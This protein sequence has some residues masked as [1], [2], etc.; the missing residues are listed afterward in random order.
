MRANERM[1]LE[2]DG[3]EA[4]LRQARADPDVLGVVLTGSHAQG[5]A[6]PGSDYDVKVILRDDAGAGTQTRYPVDAFPNVDLRVMPLREFVAYAGWD[7]PFAWDRY[8]FAHARILEDP[9][10]IISALVAEK[11]RI[12]AEHQS[13]FMRAALDAFINC[14]YRALKCTRREN[15]LCA[16]LEASEAVQHALAVIFALEGRIRPHSSTS[17]APTR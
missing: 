13:S 1:A 3:F 12:P 8:S 10:G 4:L 6:T 15:R 2:D 11:G 9:S 16:R 14:V 17:C 7:T 5:L